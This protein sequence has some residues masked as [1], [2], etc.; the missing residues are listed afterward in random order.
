MLLNRTRTKQIYNRTRARLRAWARLSRVEPSLGGA[1][2][3]GGLLRAPAQAQA[4]LLG[5]QPRLFGRLQLT[6]ARRLRCLHPWMHES[7]T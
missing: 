3:L 6:L 4:L 7:L 5:C 1:R 2:G